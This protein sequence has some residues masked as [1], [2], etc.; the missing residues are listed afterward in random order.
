MRQAARISPEHARVQIQLGF[1]EAE[2]RDFA[3]AERAFRA[4]I[5]LDPGNISA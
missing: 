1:A 3:A 2:A 5:R 4:A